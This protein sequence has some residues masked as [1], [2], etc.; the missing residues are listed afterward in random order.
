MVTGDVTVT[1][2]VTGESGVGK[3]IIDMIVKNVSLPHTQKMIVCPIYVWTLL[4]QNIFNVC[5]QFPVDEITN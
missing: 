5:F 4:L 3:F 1:T 2:D